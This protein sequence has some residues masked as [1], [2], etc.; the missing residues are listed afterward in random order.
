MRAL[1]FQLIA[2]QLHITSRQV[3]AVDELLQNGSTIPFIARYRKEDTGSLD[4]VMLTTIRNSLEQL[5]ALEHRREVIRNSLA[6]R[7]LLTRE[8][9]NRLLAI[10]SMT[11]MEDFYLPY[12]PKRRT[13][14][15]VAREKGLEPLA[16]KLL[17]QQTVD[18][19][20]AAAPYLDPEKEVH[21]ID[22]ALAGARDIVAEWVSEDPASRTL[23][24]KL[25]VAEGII[26]AKVVKG[27][28]AAG[29]KFR[30]YFAWQEK[31]AA[32]AG[33]RLLAM[34][35][36]EKEKI[37]SITIRP[38]EE[39]AL[40]LL[41]QRFVRRDNP[42]G[43]QI[44]TAVEDSYKRLL[45]PALE[46]EFRRSLRER[47]EGEAIKVFADNL[48]ELLLASP[49]GQKRLLALDPGFRTGAKLVCL[50]GQGQLLH[51]DIIYPTHSQKKVTEAA[52]VIKTLCHRYAIEAIAIG[53]GTASRETEAFIRSLDLDGT[54]DIVM[55][56]EAGASVY[57]ASEVARTEFPDHDLTVRGAVSIGRRLQDPLA[58]LVKI[59][60]KAIGVGQYQHDVDQQALKR[61]LDE[62]VSSCVNI[63][64][65]EVNTASPE[66]LS[67]VSGLS[68]VLAHNIVRF[69]NEQGPFSSRQQLLKVPRLGAKAFEQ[70]AGFLRI[71]NG[72]NPLDASAVHPERYS[73]V[74]Q[75]AQECGCPVK[76]LMAS[77]SLR[78]QINLQ[79]YISSTVG[80]PTLSDIM[81]ELARP[82]RDPRRK[83]ER[84]SFQEGICQLEDLKPGMKL[85]GLVTNV[86]RFGAFVDIG[87]HQDGLVHISQLADRYVRDPGEVVK[88]QQQVMVTVMEVDRERRRIALSLRE[89][90]EKP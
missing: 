28:E 7:Q 87:V 22:D 64:G 56:N 4:E 26:V 90:P 42:A 29:S 62:V 84:F 88:V 80:L 20:A 45:V 83:F 57:S 41:R 85:P 5:T 75:M 36:G 8:L 58:E 51:H 54:I 2:D 12:R 9:E 82:G 50:D 25:F 77:E 47:A 32:I 24:R 52:A 33:H 78:Q 18:L 73:L 44:N 16:T 89:R 55:V 67:S 39:N 21:S 66:L 14:A 49:L 79:R 74:N 30:D 59:D 31:A 6:D 37:L 48:R 40:V 17:A 11:E 68:P 34:L 15:S 69:R 43:H 53:N 71:R 1:F 13:R 19:P 76:E 81:A 10:T 70:A 72:S 35:R 60:P 23:L 38:P 46:N 86:T 61:R 65:V 27:K 63:V 3:Q